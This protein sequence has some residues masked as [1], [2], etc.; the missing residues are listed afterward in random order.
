MTSGVYCRTCGEEM[1][2]DGY[3]V[4]LH[5]PGA[6]D[7]DSYEP[8]AAPVHCADVTPVTTPECPFPCGWS[9]LHKIAVQD[10]AYLAKVSWPD[11]EDGGSVPRAVTMRL[12]DNLIRV[13]RAMLNPARAHC[14]D[15]A[16]DAA[17]W[18]AFRKCVATNDMGFLERVQEYVQSA[19]YGPDHSDSD[20]HEIP[21]H[22]IDAANDAARGELK[23]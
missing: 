8:D 17:R 9:E 2:G 6:T 11:D 22:I 3:R 13:C 21:E 23:T 14:A 7:Y 4:V 10:A 16:L 1:S 15:D 19:G 12:A 5:C 20:D 18:R